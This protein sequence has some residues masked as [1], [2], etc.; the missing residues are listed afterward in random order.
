MNESAHVVSPECTAP[1]FEGCT[2][3][4]VQTMQSYDKAALKKALGVSISLASLNHTRYQSWPQQASK[5]AGFAF[6]GPA[7]KALDMASLQQADLQFAQQHVRI[8]DALYGILRPLDSIKPYRLEMSNKVNTSK[9][10]SMYSFWGN[11]LTDSLNSELSQALQTPKFIINCASQ[12]Y[13]K[14]IELAVLH[15]PVYTV[16]FPGPSIHA[17]AARGAMVRYIVEKRVSKPE[18]LQSFTGLDGEWCYDEQQST[19]QRLVFLRGPA[20]DASGV[21][22]FC[23]SVTLFAEAASLDAELKVNA[24]EEQ[25]DIRVSSIAGS[26]QSAAKAKL[27]NEACQCLVTLLQHKDTVVNRLQQPCQGPSLPV[28]NVGQAA[29]IEILQRA[30]VQPNDQPINHSLEWALQFRDKPA[31]WSTL[32]QPAPDASSAISMYHTE[33]NGV[34]NVMKNICNLVPPE[35]CNIQT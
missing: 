31:C 18:Q 34:Q 8:L 5:A 3:A 32:L 14:A 6:D 22:D 2:E 27:G 19:E 20:A 23:T 30:A 17:K 26:R 33:V 11:L 35:A 10:S 9:G 12:E 7:Y 1:R 29:L 15:Y 16:C 21:Q 4:L 24:E 25:A 28:E 13:F